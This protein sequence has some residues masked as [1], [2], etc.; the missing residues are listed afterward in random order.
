[1][2]NKEYLT[3][4]E[5]VADI[6]DGATIMFADFRRVW[7]ARKFSLLLCTG[8]ALG[9]SPEFRIATAESTDG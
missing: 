1:M 4:D 5:A 2:K 8:K 3:F 9:T 7:V 6:S